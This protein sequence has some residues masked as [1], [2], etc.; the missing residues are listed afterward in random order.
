MSLPD[1]PGLFYLSDLQSSLK[2]TNNP[3]LLYRGSF[4]DE[5]QVRIEI[6]RVGL[7]IVLRNGHK[8]PWSVVKI[9]MGFE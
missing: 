5:A 6:L 9:Q 8:K 7:D 4:Y 3:V 2:N 1:F